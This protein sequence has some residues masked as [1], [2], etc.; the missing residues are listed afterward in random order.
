MNAPTNKRIELTVFIQRKYPAK[1][2]TIIG[3]IMAIFLSVLTSITC[4]GQKKLTAGRT[5]RDCR[6]CPEMIVVPAGNFTSNNVSDDSA[7]NDKKIPERSVSINQFA[8]G[9]FAITR[10]QWATYVAAT[11]RKVTV[12]T[13]DGVLPKKQSDNDPVGCVSWKEVQEYILWLNHNTGK[14]YRLLTEAEWEYIMHGGTNKAGP[15]EIEDRCEIQANTFEWVEDCFASSCSKGTIRGGNGSTP[16]HM[17]RAAYREWVP[18]PGT[19]IK[20]YRSPALVF[21]VAK[22]L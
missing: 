13:E 3:S 7:G 14:V 5:F 15:L 2:L 19:T 9:R 20:D 8:V 11:K 16:S 12:C 6:T 4:Y 10:R 17:I 18:T 1:L 21:R 22:T